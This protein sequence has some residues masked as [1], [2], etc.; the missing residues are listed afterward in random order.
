MNTN[1]QRPFM[2]RLPAGYRR[3]DDGLFRKEVRFDVPNRPE[4]VNVVTLVRSSTGE[5]MRTE[6][7][8]WKTK[9]T[10]PIEK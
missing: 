10:N 6:K 8:Q 2:G 7:G 1:Q 9:S 5:L 4:V 3:C